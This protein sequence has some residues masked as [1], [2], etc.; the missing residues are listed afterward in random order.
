MQ[1]D[2]SSLSY[3][4]SAGDT[5][6]LLA[7]FEDQR[8]GNVSIIGAGALHGAHDDSVLQ[9]DGANTNRLK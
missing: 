6:A 2:E 8:T 5:G 4:K 7:I 3:G 1:G 9:V